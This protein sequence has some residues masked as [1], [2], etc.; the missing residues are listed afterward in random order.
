M[1]EFETP[2]KEGCEQT[3]DAFRSIDLSL[4]NVA[5]LRLPLPVTEFETFWFCIA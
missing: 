5:S 4:G 2:R 1:I 3:E